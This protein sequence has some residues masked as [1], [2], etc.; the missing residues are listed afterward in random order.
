MLHYYRQL[1]PG[2][3]EALARAVSQDLKSI[4]DYLNSAI[5]AIKQKEKIEASWRRLSEPQGGLELKGRLYRIPKTEVVVSTALRGYS[6]GEEIYARGG[7]Y[8]IKRKEGDDKAIFSQRYGGE[9]LFAKDDTLHEAWV[10]LLKP[11]HQVIDD[12]VDE[13]V[14][15]VEDGVQPVDP[16]A[17]LLL[18]DELWSSF[19]SR[20]SHL[21][22]QG[23]SLSVHVSREGI[24][25]NDTLE[26]LVDQSLLAEPYALP[27][28]LKQRGRG[29]RDAGHWIQLIEKD[30]E[31]G[32]EE[33]MSPL[34]YFLMMTSLSK[35]QRGVDTRCLVEEMMST[36]YAY[37][38]WETGRGRTAIPPRMLFSPSKSIP[39]SSRDS[40][41][42]FEPCVTA[43]SRSIGLC[44]CCS[45]SVGSSS[46]GITVCQLSPRAGTY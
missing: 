10:E 32:E 6:E 37:T 40:L 24:L 31:G 42:L 15:Y 1:Y 45:S 16:E 13:Y 46:Y 12:R 9:K 38:R 44:L 21:Q 11:T 33:T 25:L 5:K 41:R 30:D 3:E 28:L 8:T 14:V 35:I 2:Q 26:D 22:Y 18:D 34:R 19:L 36:N 29:G 23:E 20:V 43:L 4:E 39:T 27:V 17:R 7:R